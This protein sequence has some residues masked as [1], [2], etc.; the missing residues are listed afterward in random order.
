MKENMAEKRGSSPVQESAKKAAEPRVRTHPSGKVFYGETS[1]VTPVHFHSY[2]ELSKNTEVRQKMEGFDKQYCDFV[3]YIMRI[4]HNIWEERGIGVIYDTYHDDVTMHCGSFNLQG[5]NDVVSN[6]LQTLHAFPDRRLV[7][8]NVVWSADPDGTFYS[9]HRI[10]SNA[11][12]L[13]DSGFGPA[14]GKKAFFRTTVDC[15]VY[16]NRIVEE[17]LVRDNLYIVK[18]LG[19]DPVEVA[20]RMAKGFKTKAPALQ[21]RFGLAENRKGQ[22]VPELTINKLTDDK[23]NFD[24]GNFILSMYEN[25]WNYRYFNKV[26]DYYSENAVIHSICNKELMGEAQI[27]GMLVSLFASVPNGRTLIERVTCNEIPGRDAWDVSVRWRISGM[28]EGIGFFGQPSGK[29]LEIFG[30][31]HLRIKDGMISE[32]WMTFDGLDVLRQIHVE[33]DDEFAAAKDEFKSA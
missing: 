19:F 10:V 32:E 29:P 16:K 18:Q 20:K 15:K 3:D 5:M 2:N 25:V 28:H 26:R 4:T 31:N 27:Q 1:E 9:S 22:F 30:I 23:G 21:S 6:T 24:I 33:N 13:G 8:E 14:T 12:N 17:W 11:T 7:G